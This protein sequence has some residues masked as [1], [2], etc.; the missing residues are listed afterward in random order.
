MINI[1]KA[2][3]KGKWHVFKSEMNYGMVQGYC[4]HKGAALNVKQVKKLPEDVCRVCVRKAKAKG[5]L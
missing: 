3:H 1:F 4:E 5:A 2:T